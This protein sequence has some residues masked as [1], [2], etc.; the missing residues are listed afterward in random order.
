MN[1][2]HDIAHYMDRL[3][4]MVPPHLTMIFGQKKPGYLYLGTFIFLNP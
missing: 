3:S 1:L 2:L 4:G